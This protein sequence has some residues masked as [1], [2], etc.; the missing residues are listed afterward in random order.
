MSFNL[1]KKRK[2]NFH[3]F[4]KRLLLGKG[5][6]ERKIL[7]GRARGIKM[8]INP[9]YKFQRLI[10]A[11]E[12]EIQ[13]L[14]VNYSKRCTMFF[15]VGASDGYYSL[16]FRKYNTSGPLFVFDGNPG[17][18]EIQSKHFA[19]N[20]TKGYRQFFKFVSNTNDEQQISLDSF[21][22]R[23]DKVLIKADVEGRELNVLRGAVQLLRNNKCFLLV[24]THSVQLERDCVDFLLQLGYH[25]KI[26]KNAW[27]RFFLP[28]RRPLAHNRWLAA[29]K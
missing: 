27:W 20:N 10:G 5:L 29:W 7:F 2:N 22:I 26:I 21:D 15:D 3:N 6:S 18:K 9:D 14:F 25:T 17:F 8:Y 24:E 1:Y 11:D 13:S 4:I 16:L 28:E 12:H 19:L 23:N